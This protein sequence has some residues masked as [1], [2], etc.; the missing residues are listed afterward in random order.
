MVRDSKKKEEKPK[1]SP[2]KKF[3]KKRAPVYLAVIAIFIVFVVPQITKSDLQDKF[4]ENLSEEDQLVLDS[5]MSYSGP[6]REGYTLIE[7]ISNQINEEYPNEQIYDNKKTIVDVSISKL[8]EQ[9]YQVLFNFESYKGSIQYDWN[10]DIQ[11]GTVKG[12]DEGSQN[13]KN[14][15]D[16]YD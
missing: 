8:D 2:F 6:D 16:F 4:P 3:L 11:T 9:N 15:V 14:L 7:A 12:N 13:M 10:I 1:E 5:L